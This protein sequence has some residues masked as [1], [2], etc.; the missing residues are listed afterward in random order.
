MG[1][2]GRGS[3]TAKDQYGILSSTKHPDEAWEFV[4]FMISAEGQRIAIETSGLMPIRISLLPEYG[5]LIPGKNLQAVAE[6]AKIATVDPMAV[7]P[8]ADRVAPLINGAITRILNRNEAPAGQAIQEIAG[9]VRQVV[10][11]K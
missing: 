2:G 4:K 10:S 6:A 7:I 5:R 9:A 8:N 1:K 11:G 3:Y